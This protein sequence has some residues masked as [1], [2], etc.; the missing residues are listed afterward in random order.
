MNDDFFFG[1]VVCWSSKIIRREPLNSAVDKLLTVVTD[2]EH[3]L[4]EVKMRDLQTNGESKGMIGQL[5]HSAG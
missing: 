3:L 1:G 5:M 2:V 4:T